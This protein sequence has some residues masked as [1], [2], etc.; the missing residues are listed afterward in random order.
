MSFVI[1][2]M[3]AIMCLLWMSFSFDVTVSNKGLCNYGGSRATNMLLAILL[4]HVNL[5]LM[6]I[7]IYSFCS[8]LT[9]LK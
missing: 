2:I 8:Y 1:T 9:N 4:V 6:C 3:H 7:E 5:T